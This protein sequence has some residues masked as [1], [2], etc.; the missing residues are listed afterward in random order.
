[1]SIGT[2]TTMC[3]E[4]MMDVGVDL[5]FV[6][7]GVEYCIATLGWKKILRPYV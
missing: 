1:M 7:A 6:T 5:R 3:F 2:S 4:M